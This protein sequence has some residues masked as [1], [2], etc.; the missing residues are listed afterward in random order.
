MAEPT[1]KFPIVREAVA[2]FADREHFQ[3][4]V[5]EL[6]AAGFEPT[7]LSVLARHDSLD[8]A[9]SLAGYP[10]EPHPWLPAGL[11]DEIKWVGPLTVAGIVL[12]S[13]GPIAAGLGALVAAGL[14]GAALKEVLDRY[15]T[16]P[17]SEEFA[18]ALAAGAVLLW[19]RCADDD[20]EIRATRI[21]AAAGG[22][23]VHIHGRSPI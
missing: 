5:G 19:V 11:T 22:Q 3:A 12:L 4:A 20:R 6:F 15:T 10:K 1:E 2:S 8:A 7:D 21:L 9:G 16:R 23:N 17:H 14:G 18:A 13:G